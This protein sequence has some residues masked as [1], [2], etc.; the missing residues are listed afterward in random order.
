MYN[1]IKI[2]DVNL[3][4]TSKNAHKNLVHFLDLNILSSAQLPR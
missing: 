2:I 1:D 4:F 3:T